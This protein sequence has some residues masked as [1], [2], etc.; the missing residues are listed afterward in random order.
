M[1]IFY[2][3]KDRDYRKGLEKRI[4]EL[5]KTI[6]NKE[7]QFLEESV[8]L[9]KENQELIEMSKKFQQENLK[10]KKIIADKTK[11]IQYYYGKCGGLTKQNNSLKKKIELR[12]DE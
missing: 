9:K 1:K 8:A 3:K 6:S 11:T 5:H 12:D 7:F 10:L 4:S 2:T